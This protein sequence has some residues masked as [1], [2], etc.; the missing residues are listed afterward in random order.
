M[1]AR[2]FNPC[3]ADVPLHITH[4]VV[5][6]YYNDNGMAI[7]TVHVVNEDGSTG[8]RIGPQFMIRDDAFSFA[9]DLVKGRH[10]VFF[11]GIKFERKKLG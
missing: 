5:G 7:W 1:R 9:E 11:D 8:R 2:P 10:R 6:P 3:V 4:R